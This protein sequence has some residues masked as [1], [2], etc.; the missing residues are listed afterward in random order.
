MVVFP[1]VFN[2]TTGQNQDQGLARGRDLNVE[3]VAFRRI[4]RDIILARPCQEA[5]EA[6]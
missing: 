3:S 1:R 6:N 5:I 2:Q 4:P